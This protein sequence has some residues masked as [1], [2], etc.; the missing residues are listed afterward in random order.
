MHKLLPVQDED[1]L[2]KDAYTNVVV[3]VDKKAYENYVAE[4]NLRVSQKK[5][6]EQCFREI[7]SIKGDI[8]EIK[9]LLLRIAQK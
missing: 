6:L 7:D 1:G 5:G 9:E 2:M 8:S 3:N 4:R